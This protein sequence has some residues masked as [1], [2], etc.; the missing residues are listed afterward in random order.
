M[1]TCCETKPGKQHKQIDE[2]RCDACHE[3][4]AHA[5]SPKRGLARTPTQLPAIAIANQIQPWSEPDAMPARNAPI[6][7]PK[8]SRAPIP[9]LSLIHI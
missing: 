2:F 7:H 5:A 1:I 9:I 4:P 3:R 8:P 6:L